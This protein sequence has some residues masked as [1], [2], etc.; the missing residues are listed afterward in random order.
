MTPLLRF[1]T[2][3]FAWDLLTLQSNS[4]CEVKDSPHFRKSWKLFLNGSKA[5]VVFDQ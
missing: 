4:S 3:H 2:S 5:T 1:R